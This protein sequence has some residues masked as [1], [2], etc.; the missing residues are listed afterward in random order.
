MESPLYQYC[1]EV[2]NFYHYI[3][4]YLDP[5]NIQYVIF[6]STTTSFYNSLITKTRQHDI[7]S[8]GTKII[9]SSV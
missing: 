6:Q 3:L 4:C 5:R 7:D 8:D 2:I 1:K 9:Y